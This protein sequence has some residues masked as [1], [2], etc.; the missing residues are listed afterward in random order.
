MIKDEDLVR[1]LAEGCA[2]EKAYD[3][4]I[5]DVSQM[6]SLTEYFIIASGR[7]TKHVQ[8]ICDYVHEL[9][10]EQNIAPMRQEGYQEG[11]WVIMDYNAVI[12]HVFNDDRRNHYDL[13]RLWGDAVIIEINQAKE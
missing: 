4:V 9:L 1:L 2:D 8:S 11:A 6:T 13:E 10:S 5:M 3:I 12:L 7:N